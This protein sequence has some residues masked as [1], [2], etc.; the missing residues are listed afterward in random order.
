MHRLVSWDV[1]VVLVG[2]P[3][4]GKSTVGAHLA[5]RLGVGFVDV[6]GLIEER[7]GKTIAEIFVDDGEAAFR[8]LE[9]ATTLEVLQQPGVVSLGGGAVTSPAIRA[10]LRGHHVVWLEVSVTQATRRVGM[11]AVRPL[12]L[13][14]VR[15]RLVQ[16]MAERRPL[17][18]EVAT[19]TIDTSTAKP[20]A[21]AREIEERLSAAEEKERP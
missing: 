5:R 7:T 9:V 19:I 8:E 6:D 12:L 21:L 18:E 10:A 2:A 3:G 15:S 11:N 1:P 20:P 14:N 17:Y 16:L 4:A 13:G